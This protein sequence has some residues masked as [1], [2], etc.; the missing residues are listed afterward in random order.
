MFSDPFYCGKFE[1]PKESGNWYQ[2]SHETMITE[3][4]YD[5]VQFLLGR[6]S[7]PRP[8]NK[9]FA[10]TGLIRC[11]ECGG[12]ITAEDKVKRQKNGNVHYYT[13]YHC[14][15]RKNPNCSQKT[16]RLEILEKQIKETL[17]KIYIPEDFIAWA[18]DVLKKENQKEA[19]SRNQIINSQQ[20]KYSAVIVKI[21]GLI[22]MR[23]NGEIC[24]ED[25]TRRRGELEKEKLGLTELL[26]DSDQRVDDWL[27]DAEKMFNFAEQAQTSFQNGTL[28]KKKEI[29]TC[30][31]SNLSLINGKLNIELQKPLLAIQKAA[32]E[33][34]MVSERLEP[35]NL[36]EDKGKMRVIYSQ[37]PI[38]LRGW[39][40]NPRPIGYT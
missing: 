30:L 35:L 36:C 32:F 8:Q 21:D 31:G 15:K 4:E 20:R 12:I 28:Q 13:Y 9:E 17:E 19:G 25:F 24:Q 34:K 11:G 40:S 38:L 2:G 16:I 18:M 26:R 1:Y 37:N 39:D 29:L 22:D 33:V 14:T 10:F 7:N 27:D 5:Q 3:K 6:R 23:A